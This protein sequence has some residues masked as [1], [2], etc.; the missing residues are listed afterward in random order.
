MFDIMLVF[1]YNV[2]S[3]F[4]DFLVNTFTISNVPYVMIFASYI[5][6]CMVEEKK[7]SQMIG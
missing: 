7:F 3:K 5:V 6:F 2:F 1:L 4:F